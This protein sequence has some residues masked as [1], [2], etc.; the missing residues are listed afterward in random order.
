MKKVIFAGMAAAMLSVSC[1]TIARGKV[2]QQNRADFNQ[3]R[4][5][6]QLTSVD[7]DKSFKIKPFDEGADINCFVGSQWKLTPNNYTGSYSLNGGGDCPTITQP[8]KFEVKDGNTFL[9]K[10]IEDGTKAKHN[11]AGYSLN[12]VGQDPNHFALR[13]N[14]QFEGKLIPVTYH[15]N[16]ISN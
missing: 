9:F 10:K 8:I 1:S 5:D 15:F 12:L 3:L 14:V 6:W 13:Q 4:G 2:A 11:T 16:K 7:Y